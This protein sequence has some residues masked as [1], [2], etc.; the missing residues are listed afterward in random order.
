MEERASPQNKF[1]VVIEDIDKLFKQFQHANEIRHSMQ[2][3]SYHTSYEVG[4]CPLN[5]PAE[6]VTVA[7]Q[8]NGKSYTLKATIFSARRSDDHLR[9]QEIPISAPQ[10]SR[11]FLIKQVGD[12]IIVL[13]NQNREEF[14]IRSE[15]SF[16]WLYVEAGKSDYNSYSLPP[17]IITDLDAFTADLNRFASLLETVVN[18]IYISP[19]QV[20]DITL[21]L[22][23]QLIQTEA[24]DLFSKLNGGI[25]KDALK[26]VLEIENPCISFEDVGGQIEA[27]Q[28]M[29]KIS[30]ALTHL[31]L[32]QSWGTTPPQGVLL[33][34]PPGTGKTLLAKALA[35]E[36]KARL[37]QV[38]IADIL[39]MW[40][41]QS[42]KIMQAVF[43]MVRE[44][45]GPCI[46]FFDELDAFAPNRGTAHEATQRVIS[47]LLINLNEISS[48]P[49]I[50]VVAATNRPESIDPA[51]QRAGRFNCI[52][53][54]PLPDKEGIMH[55][56][57][58]H[59]H[60]AEKVANRTLLG[61][62]YDPLR[63]AS[64]TEGL[65]G[66]D[67]AEIVRRVLEEKVLEQ[68][69]GRDPDLVSTE[70]VLSVIKS[71]E[72]TKKVHQTLSF[73]GTVQKTL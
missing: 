18:S 33:V 70:D 39:S 12:T 47:T 67:I 64:P 23:P 42:E 35:S 41:S 45:A 6:K 1:R 26:K 4:S 56:F 43:D 51:I 13:D 9:H 36:T 68:S 52:I 54:V 61:K 69:L 15:R 62:D 31:D 11:S 58:I 27:K 72:R 53:D 49:N 22:R 37:F 46:L 5:Q 19:S 48:S 25:S 63:I 32:Y 21:Y 10:I 30:S 34:G 8:S 17:K 2:G 73:P 29:F 14:T 24:E 66:A 71:Y 20:P 7:G 44:E 65:S 40:Y 3:D 57:G 16:N 59:F 55:I 50:M 28:E 60:N 38:K